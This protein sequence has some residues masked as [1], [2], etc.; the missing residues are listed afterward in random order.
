MLVADVRRFERRD[1]SEMPRGRTMRRIDR[2]SNQIVL[3]I[4][5]RVRIVR[6]RIRHGS[7]RLFPSDSVFG[8]DW[9]GGGGRVVGDSNQRLGGDF[10][11]WIDENGLI[12]RHFFHGNTTL[13]AHAH[14][15][16]FSGE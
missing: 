15:V 11:R 4:H 8:A 5:M 1:V 12:T 9:F 2:V 13:K 6:P 14:L 7:R 10:Q 16:D 3:R